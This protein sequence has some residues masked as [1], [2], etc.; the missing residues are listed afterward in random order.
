M[1]TG[2]HFLLTYACNI[3]CDHCFLFCG[4]QAEGT[5]TLAQTEHALDE[6][7]KLGGVESVAFEGGEPFLQYELLLAGV[8][9]ARQRGFKVSIVTNAS[10][11]ISEEQAESLLAPLVEAGVA[12]VSVSDDAYHHGQADLTPAKRA[13]AAAK[14]LGLAMSAICIE[15]PMVKAAPAESGEPGEP[16]IGGGVMFRGRA[17][18]LVGDLPRRR[19]ESFTECTHEKLGSPKRV[20]LDAYGNIHLCQGL[21]MGNIWQTPLSQLVRDY[22]AEQHPIC[23]PLL[24][25]GP[26]QLAREYGVACEEGYVDACHF[27]YLTRLALLERFPEYLAPRQVYGL[28]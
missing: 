2:I 26:A 10:W 27:C 1:L 13:L 4:P 5:F 7:V 24:H 20:H 25:G 15:R 22:D 14:K 21:L 11:A 8:R 12:S 28:T 19:W 16:I 9:L 18:N 23:R 17:V 6:L 3:G